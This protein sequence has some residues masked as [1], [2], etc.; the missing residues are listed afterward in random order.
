MST[1]SE[2]LALKWVRLHEAL[3]AKKQEMNIMTLALQG[4]KM[5]TSRMGREIVDVYAALCD[6]LGLPSYRPDRSHV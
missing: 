2:E 3:K 6:E 5:E 1:K 4:F